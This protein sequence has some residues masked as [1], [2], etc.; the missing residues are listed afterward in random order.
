M[1]MLVPALLGGSVMLGGGRA[2]TWPARLRAALWFGVIV[3]VVAAPPYVRNVVETGNPI[4]PFAAA[5]FPSRHWSPEAGAYLDEYY[6]QYRVDRAHRRAGTPYEALGV[7]RFPWDLTMRPE[8]FERAARQSLD[9]GPF[10]L[11]FLPAACWL[12]VRRRRVAWVLAFGGAYVAVIATGAWAHPRYV[13]PGVVLVLACG[14]AGAR[15][16][17]GRRFAPVVA[18]TLLG[19]V[20]LVGRLAGPLLGDQVRLLAGRLDR[21]AYLERHSERY[22]FWRRACPLVAPAGTVLVLEKIPHPYFIGC[23]F[24][25][26]SYLEQDLLAYRTLDGPAALAAAARQLGVTHVA[27]ARPDLMRAADP[28]EARVAGLW[29]A[30]TESLGAPVLDVPPYVLYVLPPLVESPS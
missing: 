16:L 22:R 13:L 11:A 27:V 10:A 30:W 18:A 25:L 8:S 5:R 21:A 20:V 7:F 28:Y 2:R 24:V 3:M 9:V 4:H 15:S 17:L 14:V 1:G 23:R 29:R 12:A 19:Q 6:R 26:G